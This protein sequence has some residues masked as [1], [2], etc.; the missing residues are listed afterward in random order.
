MPRRPRQFVWPIEPGVVE[1]FGDDGTKHYSWSLRGTDWP[2]VL[3]QLERAQGY[4]LRGTAADLRQVFATP[5]SAAGTQEEG[6]RG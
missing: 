4:T 6:E 1:V 3:R 2:D 5:P